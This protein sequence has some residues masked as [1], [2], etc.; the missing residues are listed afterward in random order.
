MRERER[1][2]KA[3]SPENVDERKRESGRGVYES[4]NE[5]EREE[6]GKTRKVRERGQKRERAK[7]EATDNGVRKR[8][9]GGE[10]GR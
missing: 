5:K 6:E 4:G 9:R 7:K 8:K 2:G 3:T 10:R 1:G